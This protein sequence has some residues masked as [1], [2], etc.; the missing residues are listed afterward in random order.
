MTVVRRTRADV[1]LSKIDWAALQSTEDAEIE[2]QIAADPDTAP[3]FTAAE[4]ARAK[5]VVPDAVT[6]ALV[7]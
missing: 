7:R 1:D 3:I 6:R 2:A 5:R 4:L